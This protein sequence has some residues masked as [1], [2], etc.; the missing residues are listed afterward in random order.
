MSHDPQ[1]HSSAPDAAGDGGEH[2]AP[3]PTQ[4][5]TGAGPQPSTSSAGLVRSAA[6]T[7][8]CAGSAG[9]L[10]WGGQEAI[11][12]W[13][14]GGFHGLAWLTNLMMVAAWI[15]ARRA[16]AAW[17][18]IAA[19]AA[20]LGG[21]GAHVATI[22]SAFGNNRMNW[23]VAEPFAAM[24]WGVGIGSWGAWTV[25]WGRSFSGTPAVVWAIMRWHAGAASV[26]FLLYL[27]WTQSPALQELQ[28]E[29]GRWGW[30][31]THG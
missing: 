1:G 6:L 27:A 13:S 14:E 26:A 29:I 18:M 12:R 17:A 24:V 2:T 16:A 5:P 21:A 15:G 10:G 7:L 9:A 8:L 25:G 19:A 23:W 30:A 3:A 22:A 4:G 28:S 31:F 11:E 20:L